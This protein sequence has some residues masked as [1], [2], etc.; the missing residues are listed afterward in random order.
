MVLRKNRMI[1]NIIGRNTRKGDDMDG[2]QIFIA[3][4]L[5]TL[6]LCL[7]ILVLVG[8]MDG[9]SRKKIEQEAINRGHAKYSYTEKDYGTFVWIDKA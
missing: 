4:S 8:I 3:G 5:L 6:L 2:T 9:H 1:A 7:F